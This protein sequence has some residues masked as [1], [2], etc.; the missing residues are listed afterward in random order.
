MASDLNLPTRLSDPLDPL[1]GYQLRRASTAM[2]TDLGRSLAPL[3]LRPQEASVLL[4]IKANPNI[5]QS[6]IG[7]VLA[8]QRA[9]MA[10]LAATLDDK[11][12][13]AREQVDGRSLGLTVTPAGAAACE[14][15]DAV[16]AEHERRFVAAM[17]RALY[18][19]L[20][21]TL[22]TLWST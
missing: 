15:I 3:G 21:D 6:E 9:N 20:T 11:G 14:E 5:T 12:L 22:R 17:P 1:L 19:Q 18:R 4:L 8:I 7:K 2:F 13:I 10:P 16:I